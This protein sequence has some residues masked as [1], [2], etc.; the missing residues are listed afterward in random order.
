M[1]SSKIV[2]PA[3]TACEYMIKHGLSPR[4]HVSRDVEEDFEDAIGT[5]DY[6]NCLV[7]GDVME[8]LSRDFVDES[9][10]LMLKCPVK[11][12]IIALGTGRYYKDSGRLRMDTGAYAKAFEYCLGVESI[13]IGKPSKEFFEQA[14][15]V[16]G[17]SCQ[18]TIM[19]GDDLISDVGGAQKLGLRGFLVRTG[20][21]S[22][23][24]ETNKLVR[25]DHIFNDLNEAMNVLCSLYP[26]VQ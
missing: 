9:L 15:G 25:P 14:M 26:K 20:K 22:K 2:S 7:I 3:P 23:S 1:T 24:D 4:L 16:V 18:D 6:P 11:P 5:N 17:G 19:I 13:N 12:K 10:E 21:F 8:R